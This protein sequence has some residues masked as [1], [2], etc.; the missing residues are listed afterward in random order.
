MVM[1]TCAI[2]HVPI[3]SSN[4]G[5]HS[6]IRPASNVIRLRAERLR[7]ISIEPGRKVMPRAYSPCNFR[8]GS[9]TGPRISN[10][11]FT[12]S[13]TPF[14]HQ[15]KISGCL[16]WR[17]LFSAYFDSLAGLQRAYYCASLLAHCTD[18]SDHFFV[19]R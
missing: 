8:Y 18:D 3:H 10:V 17:K 1:I 9:L 5:L 2:S 16:V 7:P 14:W 15:K 6:P 4:C 13:V 19:V 11:T 12:F